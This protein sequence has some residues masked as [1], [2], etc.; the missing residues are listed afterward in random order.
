MVSKF[1]KLEWKLILLLVLS[2]CFVYLIK[3]TNIHI[4]LEKILLNIGV[5]NFLIGLFLASLISTLFLLPFTGMLQLIGGILLGWPAFFFTSLPILITIYFIASISS[6]SFYNTSNSIDFNKNNIVRFYKKND[7]I[8]LIWLRISGAVPLSVVNLIT[9]RSNLSSN[10]KAI[11]IL[12][13]NGLPSIL[14]IG[15]C[16]LIRNQFIEIGMK[17]SKLDNV[18]TILSKFGFILTIL[19]SILILIIILIQKISRNFNTNK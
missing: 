4:Y 16:E 10:K 12:I 18:L 19:F 14:L 15:F 2:I 6:F 7:F 11:I 8:L 3:I 1:V 5:T 9:R 17:S 13:G